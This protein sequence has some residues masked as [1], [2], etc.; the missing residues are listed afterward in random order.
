MLSKC[1]KVVNDKRLICTIMM[2]FFM[3]LWEEGRK[4][5]SVIEA[6]IVYVYCAPIRDSIVDLFILLALSI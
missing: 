4:I 2:I 6:L 3:R 5:T 1:T